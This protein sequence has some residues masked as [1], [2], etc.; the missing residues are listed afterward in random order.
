MQPRIKNPKVLI[1]TPTSIY[2][3]Y[4][5]LE[6]YTWIS[7]LTYDNYEIMMVDNSLDVHYFQKLKS[8]GIPCMHVSPVGKVPR[9]FMCQSLNKLRDYFLKNNFDIF[10]SLESDI[11]PPRNFIEKLIS[12]H[13]PVISAPYFYDFGEKSNILLWVFN[14]TSEKKFETHKATMKEGF[15]FMDGK[16]KQL[17]QSGIGCTMIAREIIKKIPFRWNPSKPEFADS[18]FYYDLMKLKI[19]NYIDTS[20]L[21]KHYSSNWSE[22]PEQGRFK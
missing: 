13:K 12:C 22:I 4:V 7:N 15:I 11:L 3:D 21:C 19:E 10:I 2:K 9:E 5:L 16:V 18:W 17:Y 20:F 1:A 8:L 14:Q 6:W